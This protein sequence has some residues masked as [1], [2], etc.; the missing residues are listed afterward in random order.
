[1]LCCRGGNCSP[2]RA[3]RP[4][5]LHLQRFK[6]TKGH[7]W[8]PNPVPGE[9]DRALNELHDLINIYILEY[10]HTSFCSRFSFRVLG[11]PDGFCGYGHKQCYPQLWISFKVWLTLGNQIDFFWFCISYCQS[12]HIEGFWAGY[13]RVCQLLRWGCTCC[14]RKENT[15][16]L[17]SSSPSAQPSTHLPLCIHTQK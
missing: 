7:W 6:V 4:L 14:H 10:I 15:P 12:G 3:R 9:N 8:C 16:P 5:V 13:C 17:F 1:M 2:P 11:C